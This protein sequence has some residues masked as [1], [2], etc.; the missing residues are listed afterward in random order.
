MTVRDASSGCTALHLAASSGHVELLRVLLSC[1]ALDALVSA[2]DADGRTPLHYAAQAHAMHAAMHVPSAWHATSVRVPH[3]CTMRVPCMHRAKFCL[4]QCGQLEAMRLLLDHGAAVNARDHEGVAPL[5]VA[6]AAGRSAALLLLDARADL[7]ATSRGGLTAL[8]AAV[9][10]ACAQPTLGC[11][12]SC[13]IACDVLPLHMGPQPF[14]RG[15]AACTAYA[16]R[17][18]AAMSRR[19]S[20]CSSEARRCMCLGL[21]LPRRG[22][23]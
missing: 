20:C 3:A 4:A 13:S 14:L 6:C 22:G 2:P 17:C 21:G 15:A 11:I 5:S 23:A 10:L 12:P 1:S 9:P 18:S 8:G 16:R 19:W 7:E